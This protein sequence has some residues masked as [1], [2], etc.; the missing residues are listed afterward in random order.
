[1]ILNVLN[2][3]Y[4]FKIMIVEIYNADIYDFKTFIKKVLIMFIKI[5]LFIAELEIKYMSLYYYDF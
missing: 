5:I 3:N 4:F 1:M 2:L